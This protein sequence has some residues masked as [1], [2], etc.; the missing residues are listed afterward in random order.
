MKILYLEC[1]MGAAGDMLLSALYELLEDKK[2][3]LEKM[4]SLGLPGVRLEAERG[5][6]CGIAGT[7]IKVTVRG[8]EEE[9][10]LDHGHGH[11]H[12][13]HHGHLADSDTVSP[14]LRIAPV[15]ALLHGAEILVV[16][17]PSGGIEI[18]PV[19]L[20]IITV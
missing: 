7:H 20:G 3:F 2:G 5:V 1:G 9:E 6:S 11:H 4:N 14:A 12:H 13:D 19:C 18:C 8:M 10:H 15:C 16:L 17:Q